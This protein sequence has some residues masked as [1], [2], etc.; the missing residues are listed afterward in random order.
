M[1]DPAE[2]RKVILRQIAARAPEEPKGQDDTSICRGQPTEL[3][4]VT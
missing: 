1:L 2:S 3:S 4:E